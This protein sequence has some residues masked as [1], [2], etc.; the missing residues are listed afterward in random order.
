MNQQLKESSRTA[1]LSDLER[2]LFLRALD[3]FRPAN[4]SAHRQCDVLH[5]VIAGQWSWDDVDRRG[6]SPS[7]ETHSQTFDVTPT[8]ANL[9]IVV[10]QGALESGG[11]PYKMGRTLRGIQERM[12]NLFAAGTAEHATNGVHDAKA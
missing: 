9:I 4:Y 8:Q 2:F 1:T 3:T 6:V 5:G 7:D 10:V 12:R 11:A